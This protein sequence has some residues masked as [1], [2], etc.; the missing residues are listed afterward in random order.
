MN[1]KALAHPL[2]REQEK[3]RR[4]IMQAFRRKSD[5]LLVGAAGTG[6]TT[7]TQVLVADLLEAGA[8]IAVTAPTNQAVQVLREM[9][10]GWG[11]KVGTV[12]FWHSRDRPDTQFRLVAMTTHAFLNLSLD[13]TERKKMLY[14]KNKGD[15][16]N[17]GPMFNIFIIDECSMISQDLQGYIDEDLFN[18]ILI[19]YIGDEA[20]LPPVG[21]DRAGCFGLEGRSELKT[22]IRQA[23]GNY[24]LEAATSIRLQQDTGILNYD[25][26]RTQME[27]GRGI[28]DLTRD[29]AAVLERFHE[30]FNSATFKWNSRSAR[31]IGYTNEMVIAINRVIREMVFGK[32]ES[33]FIVGEH[34]ICRG[35]VADRHMI[36]RQLIHTNDEVVVKKIERDT[37]LFRFKEEE[38]GKPLIEEYMPAWV[39]TL[40]SPMTGAQ[41]ECYAP[42][43]EDGADSIREQLM[44][45]KRWWH[46]HNFNRIVPDL[47]P[48]YALTAHTSQG[49]TFD[50]TLMCL[51]DIRRAE[52]YTSPKNVMQL[53]Y[54]AITR[55]RY[56]VT[57]IGDVVP[58]VPVKRQAVAPRVR[59]SGPG[60]DVPGWGNM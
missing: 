40:Q 49:S 18:D 36:S 30:T 53:L 25:W 10:E 44:I 52:A 23:K 59:T 47:R 56:T 14:K 15:K 4:E 54:T 11:H 7:L 26:A 50:H 35:P 48:I 34:V 13:E 20:Q 45:S 2:T 22:V 46:F 5:W 6:K 1:T 27:D 43:R 33:P 29:N 39:V 41:A 51:P 58:Y 37:P 19:L 57:L 32:T 12:D 16:G 9:L 17:Y 8:H 24:I 21:E 60:P 28:L 3:A 42:A 31:V 55:P 38:H